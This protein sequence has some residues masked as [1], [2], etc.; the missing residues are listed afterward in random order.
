MLPIVPVLNGTDALKEKPYIC[1]SNQIVVDGKN[2]SKDDILEIVQSQPNQA[3]N[4]SVL[5]KDARLDDDEVIALLNNGISTLFIDSAE[6]AAHLIEVGVPSVRLTM[7]KDG[8]YHFNF[9][10]V[11]KIQESQLVDVSKISLDSFNNSIISSLKTDRS[12]GLYTTLVVDENERSLGLVYSNKESISLAIETQ[13]GIYFS[14]SRNEI[15]RKGA[16]SGNV[17]QLLSVE[18]DCDGDAL[19]FV[20]R[21]GGS[22]SFCHLDTES[23]FGDFKH[24]LYGLQRLLQDRFSNA[25]EG[26][27]TKRL[28]DDSELLSA[29]IKEEAEEL[30]E[31]VEKKDIAWECADLFYFAM[32]RLV[33]NGVSLEDVEQNLNVKHM[34]ITR[35]KGDA[36]PKFIKKEEPVAPAVTEEKIFLNVVSADDKTAVEQAVTRPIQKT[37][38]I[39]NLVNPIIENVVKNGDKALIELTARFDGVE[40]ESP[41]LEAP[42]PK[43]Y[44]EGLTDEL[45]DA[46]DLS[47]ENVRKFH[48]AQM[49]TDT[50]T[51]E[52]QPGVVCSRFPRPIEKVGLY[53]PGGTA[54]LPSTALMLGV[55]AKVAGC[56]E[57]V[58]ASPPR[59]SDGRVSPE[60]VYVAGK[61]GASKI[62]LA[63]GAQAVA[64]M[65]YGTESVPKVD[66]ILGP[67]NQFVTAAK[68]Y[69][70]NDTQALCSI[71]MPA[72][73]SEVLVICDEEADVDF[74]ASDLLSQAEHGID[75][76]VILV[77]VSLSDSKIKELQNAVHEQALQ[78]PRVDIVRKCIAHSSIILCKSYEEAFQ[79][80][81]QYAPEH[82]ILQIADAE[83]YVKDVD[84][85]GSVFVGAYTPESCGDYSSGTNHTLPTYGYARQYSGVN[86]ATFQKFITSQAVTPT[87]LEN[88]G[89]A[90][91]SV[92]KVEGLDAHRNAVKIRMTK[93]GLLPTGF[94]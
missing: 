83:S 1:L 8:A 18:L 25:P 35:R 11:Q 38:E 91:M 92:A 28:F 44:L 68:M 75:S 94:E 24:G 4:V 55:P 13:T 63:G 60:V 67:G 27:Y 82:L 87:G 72:G 14:R 80:S 65:A 88:I 57:I 84:H 58:F 54:I 70:Q 5:L 76:Q 50:L 43:E 10:Q 40:L 86:T 17:Q 53:I 79:M 85:A 16:T 59:K 66:K 73:P 6:Y 19:K 23:C 26:S 77:G 21:Q 20:V 22:G 62:V 47:I 61:V 39:M 7:F 78:L 2:S 81:N 31:A 12:D 34:K 49:Q 30:T 74:V 56:K 15:W 48:E 37:A 32:A 69:V 45:R 90:V 93:L 71:D 89:R 51:V 3:H 36:K 64:S 46:L 41:V 42:F 9:G 33:A 29:K 52:T